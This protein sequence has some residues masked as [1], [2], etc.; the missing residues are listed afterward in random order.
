MSALAVPLLYVGNVAQRLP[1][2]LGSDSAHLKKASYFLS[3]VCFSLLSAEM[4]AVSARLALMGGSELFATGS[5][6]VP[7]A[8]LVK[9]TVDKIFDKLNWQNELRP[10]VSWSITIVI[11]TV[12]VS[13]ASVAFGLTASLFT[14]Y[15]ATLLVLF[16][17]LAVG[18]GDQAIS[19]F[20]KAC[21]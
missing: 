3:G 18:S 15:R 5:L 11:S 21:A 16:V 7:V 2:S 8:L 13:E 4:L 9:K 1:E 20:K 17:F 19:M 10:T 14:A 6:L 12:L